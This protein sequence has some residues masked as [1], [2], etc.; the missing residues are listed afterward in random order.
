MP[1]VSLYEAGG[2]KMFFH[3]IRPSPATFQ[4]PRTTHCRASGK[5]INNRGG[6][7]RGGGEGGEG[8]GGA[9]VLLLIA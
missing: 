8:E 7:G 3:C 4:L 9:V 1:G 6:R 5:V 2:V